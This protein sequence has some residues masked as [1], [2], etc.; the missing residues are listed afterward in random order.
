ML[1]LKFSSIFSLS[2]LPLNLNTLHENRAFVR[3]EAP[4]FPFTA[5]FGAEKGHPFVKDILDSYI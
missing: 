1:T 3:Y 4:E 2:I 5:V